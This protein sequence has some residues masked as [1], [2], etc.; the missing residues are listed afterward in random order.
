MAKVEFTSTNP[1]AKVEIENIVIDGK[2]QKTRSVLVTDDTGNRNMVAAVS[3]SYNLIH[4]ELLR[5]AADDVM[6][7]SDRNFSHLKT[8]W[9]GK[10]YL[11]YFRSDDPIADGGLHLGIMFRNSYDGSSLAMLGIYMLNKGCLNQYHSGSLFGNFEMRHMGSSSFD[12]VTV[13]D[14]LRNLQAGAENCI[15]MAPRIESMKH[16]VIDVEA[17]C[18]AKQKNL[19]PAAKWPDVLD[20]LNAEAKTQYGL[21]QSMTNVATHK[22]SDWH[23]HKYREAVTE[24]FLA[25]GQHKETNKA[26]YYD[27]QHLGAN[28]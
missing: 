24:H 14:A 6:S 5:Q 21:F 11:E 19:L 18:K 8:Y 23:G 25:N 26:E 9:D 4:N 20:C 2:E 10:R 28:G 17:V 1:F 13:E 27:H 15:R 3:P 16:E 12:T 7:R 22:L